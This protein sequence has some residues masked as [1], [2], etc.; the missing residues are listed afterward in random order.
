MIENVVVIGDSHIVP[1]KKA[2]E[3]RNLSC[4]AEFTFL[5]FSYIKE[6]G[7][8]FIQNNS[9]FYRKILSKKLKNFYESNGAFEC[10]GSDEIFSIPLENCMVFL[11]G[12][13]L[14]I[15]GF[16]RNFSDEGVLNQRGCVDLPLTVRSVQNYPNL[17]NQDGVSV[18]SDEFL[19]YLLSL[20]V[21]NSKSSKLYK[22]FH[23]RNFLS[24]EILPLPLISFSA[25]RYYLRADLKAIPFEAYSSV[26]KRWMHFLSC[27][28][29]VFSI[30]DLIRREHIFNEV[31]IDSSESLSKK[32]KDVHMSVSACQAS[33]DYIVSRLAA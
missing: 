8:D 21:K 10:A 18:Y 2:F 28:P 14:G 26:L 29:G 6:F 32:E 31:F 7:N 24:V 11:V 12:M 1:L 4:D 20:G 13:G 5:P 15:D 9:I 25:F 3:S 16:L 30:S 33:V 22:T 17:A 23:Q 19:D 27:S